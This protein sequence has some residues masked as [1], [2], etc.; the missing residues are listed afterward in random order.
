MNLMDVELPERPEALPRVVGVQVTTQLLLALLR[1]PRKPLL[2]QRPHRGELGT[3][4]AIQAAEPR[5]GA[6]TGI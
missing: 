4:D 6:L 5:L 3:R 2:Q 1:K